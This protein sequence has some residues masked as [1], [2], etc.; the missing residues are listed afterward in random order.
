[1][2]IFG[3]FSNFNQKY[4]RDLTDANTGFFMCHVHEIFSGDFG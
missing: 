3:I 1:M 2:I 4:L